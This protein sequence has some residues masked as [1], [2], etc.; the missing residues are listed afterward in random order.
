[1]RSNSHGTGVKRKV[2]GVSYFHYHL[3]PDNV[4]MYLN[5]YK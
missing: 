1:M 3:F 5:S 2:Y 4:V